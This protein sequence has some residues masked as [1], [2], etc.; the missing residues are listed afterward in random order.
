MTSRMIL[1]FDSIVSGV[2]ISGIGENA[3]RGAIY[4]HL[5]REPP[6]SG[7]HERMIGLEPTTMGWCFEHA[8]IR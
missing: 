8:P 7:F 6:F 5:K 3:D 2:L 1:L 4:P